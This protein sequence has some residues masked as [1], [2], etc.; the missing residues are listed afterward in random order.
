[1]ETSHFAGALA[2]GEIYVEEYRHEL[3]PHV[4]V[5]ATTCDLGHATAIV[6]HASEIE[7]EMIRAEWASVVHW[8]A[9][10]DYN[11]VKEVP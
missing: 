2:R 11:S 3:F 9:G 10:D 8:F 5:A 7:L 1:L 4:I 6:L